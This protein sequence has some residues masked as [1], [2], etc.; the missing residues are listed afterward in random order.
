MKDI[1][2]FEEKINCAIGF[3]KKY[4]I[5]FDNLKKISKD[6][7]NF[8]VNVP[9]IGGFST[10]KSSLINAMLEQELLKTDIIPETSIPTEIIYGKNSVEII[11]EDNIK[12]ISI[13]EY[14]KSSFKAKNVDLIKINLENEFLE[15]VSDIKIVD[16]PGFDSG[17]EVHNRAI[18]DYLPD[19]L[20]YIIAVGADEGNLRESIV[21]FLKELKINRPV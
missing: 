7:R 20:A 8:K 19:S 1:N 6:M 13:S 15:T 17:C 3:C 16:M 10:G 14:Q 11:E 18:N 9:L 5:K 2:F 4:D 21:N 12:N